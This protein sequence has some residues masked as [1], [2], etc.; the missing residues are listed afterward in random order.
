[1][2]GTESILKAVMAENIPNLGREMDIQI[3]E[4][5]KTPN[6]LNL[7]RATVRPIQ[8]KLSK[9]KTILRAVR[10]KRE[11]IYRGAPIRPLADFST[12]TFQTRRECND[13]LKILKED[14]LNQEFCTW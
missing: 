2:K 9:S 8:I 13:I 4:T 7:N 11:V 10:K 14:S 3:H 6:R 5:Q 12:E 1:M